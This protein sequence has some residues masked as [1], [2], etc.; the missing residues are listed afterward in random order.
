MK[1]RFTPQVLSAAFASLALILPLSSAQAGDELRINYGDFLGLNSAIWKSHLGVSYVYDQTLL[2]AEPMEGRNLRA[3]GW[4][5]RFHDYY[6]GQI[7]MTDA[8]RIVPAAWQSFL[9]EYDEELRQRDIVPELSGA[10]VVG[11][12]LGSDFVVG[13]ELQLGVLHPKTREPLEGRV[14]APL[15][16][17]SSLAAAHRAAQVLADNSRFELPIRASECQAMQDRDGTVTLGSLGGPLDQIFRQ[18]CPVS[19]IAIG[20]ALTAALLY[21][22]PG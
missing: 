18:S 14:F 7:V 1:R 11:A 12:Q 16:A 3:R 15:Q 19:V 6:P 2:I 21:G 5:T 22:P 17:F 9:T 13:F 20:G 4:D 8:L 10:A